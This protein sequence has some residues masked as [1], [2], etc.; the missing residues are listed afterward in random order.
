MKIYKNKKKYM[1]SSH[2]LIR[3]RPLTPS[4][5]PSLY[6]NGTI[7]NFPP[8]VPPPSLNFIVGDEFTATSGDDDDDV[9]PFSAFV[10]HAPLVAA[11]NGRREEKRG[12]TF[13]HWTYLVEQLPPFLCAKNRK[14]KEKHKL[15]IVIGLY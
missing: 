5:P 14:K 12:T 10:F 6:T 3:R 1:K 8:P 2:D 15:Q 11:H 9:F 13:E 7:E 4:L